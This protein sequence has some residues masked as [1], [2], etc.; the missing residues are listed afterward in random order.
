MHIKFSEHGFF[1]AILVEQSEK[2]NPFFCL[3][4]KLT[5]FG[6]DYGWTFSPVIPIPVK[7]SAEP[8]SSARLQRWIPCQ[9]RNDNL[10]IRKV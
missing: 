1:F 3:K 7:R 10:V 2:R 5:A 4:W 8:E 9:A 6:S